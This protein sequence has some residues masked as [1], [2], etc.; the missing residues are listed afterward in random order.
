MAAFSVICLEAVPS[1][2]RGS[3]SR[4]MI[5]PAEGIFVGELPASVRDEVWQMISQA[6]DVGRASLIYP[7]NSEQGFS[8][9]AHGESRRNMRDFDG[10]FLVDYV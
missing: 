10:M 1:A 2:V 6:S 7:T 5:E 4:W 3:L 8:V 9:L